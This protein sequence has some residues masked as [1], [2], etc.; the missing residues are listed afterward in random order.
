[1]MIDPPPC[2]P[3][4]VLLVDD[5]DLLRLGLRSLLQSLASCAS[6]NLQVLE[7]SS[8]QQALSLYA[9]HQAEIK[10][11]LL[12]LHLPDAHGVTGLT[13]LLALYPDAH[14]VILSGERDPAQMRR[15]MAEGARAYLDKSGDL[16]QVV[17]YIQSLALPGWAP[18]EKATTPTGT[19]LANGNGTER[20]LRHASGTPV[21]LTQ[22]QAQILDYVLAGHANRE[23]AH[24]VGLG[25][26][27]VKNHV[28]TLLLE[29]GVR[30]RAQLISLLR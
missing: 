13:R 5:H 2:T 21:C 25:E 27:S 6:R 15:A 30:S 23:I 22:R 18:P 14:V 12:D 8:L 17:S 7:A 26:G 3:H 19:A 4:A 29:F 16:Q 9:A 1:M 11:V 28:S 24:L 10:L 20:V